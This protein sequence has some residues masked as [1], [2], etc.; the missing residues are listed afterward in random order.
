MFSKVRLQLGLLSQTQ[1]HKLILLI[2]LQS[3]LGV[4]DI[5]GIGLIGMV[6]AI[7]AANLTYQTL[8]DFV[9]STLAFFGLENLSVTQQ[10]AVLALTSIVL[11]VVR[12]V[13]SAILTRKNLLFLANISADLSKDVMTK[14]LNLPLNQIQARENQY[15][16]YAINDGT[17]SLVLGVIGNATNALVDLNMLILIFLTLFIFDPITSIVGLIFFGAVGVIM[18]RYLKH[19]GKHLGE[20]SGELAIQGSQIIRD[21]LESYRELLI[22]NAN[23]IYLLKLHK[24]RRAFAEV[25]AN[26]SFIPY[27]SKYIFESSVIVG[28]LLI[29]AV[30]F[31]RH[32]AQ[33][34]VTS[35]TVFVAAST[36]ILPSILRFQQSLIQVNTAFGSGRTAETLINYLELQRTPTLASI[37]PSLGEFQPNIKVRELSF[38]YPGSESQAIDKCSFEITRGEMV[39]ICGP[40]GSGKST[41]IDLMIGALIP[42]SG[43]V[44]VSGV[45]PKKCFS[46][47]KDKV[48]FMSQNFMVQNSTIAENVTFPDEYKP[49]DR[50]T[51]ESALK[52]ALLNFDVSKLEAHSPV[53][54]RGELLSG[55]EKQRLGLARALFRDPEILILDEF[56]S[57]LDQ[58]TEDKVMESVESFKGKKTVIVIAHKLRTLRNAD[59]IMYINHGRI[60]VFGTLEEVQKAVPD[61]GKQSSIGV[62]K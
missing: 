37:E 16:V 53:G 47:W 34:A 4:L 54:E 13:F 22:R 32:D 62:F 33:T 44:L 58:H 7:T 23:D 30:Q 45:E 35:L 24:A 9:K 5:F 18:Y 15:Y 46:N 36:R 10:V 12:T 50:D 11:L 52:S 56:T 40:S 60:L 29:S 43:E 26:I 42:D 25:Q 51:V 17:S 28:G 14:T 19:K 48:S 31:V 20:R 27:L 1:R 55:G 39:A 2:L 38:A 21:S 8:P 41:L 49:E 6:G 59:K 3:L 57:A 61:F